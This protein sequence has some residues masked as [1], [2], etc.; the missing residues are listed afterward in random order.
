MVNEV[1]LNRGHDFVKLFLEV[2]N[3]K[4]W[5]EGTSVVNSLN[6]GVN[7]IT[8]GLDACNNDRTVLVLENL[9]SS[10]TLSSSLDC[11]IVDASS[12]INE[13]SD[14]LN[15]ITVLLQLSSEFL[16]SWVQR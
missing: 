7:G 4:S 14:V 11:F 5:Q 9:W 1:K 8:I 15:A 10:D 2:V 6:K 16:F 13:E 12:I 3:S